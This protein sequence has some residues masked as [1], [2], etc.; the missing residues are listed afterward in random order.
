[1]SSQLET[2]LAYCREKVASEGSSL[3]YATG[4]LSLEDR[5]FWLGLFSLNQELRNACMKQFE[6]GLTQIKLGWWRNTLA[7]NED[8]ANRHPV[9]VAISQHVISSIPPEHWEALIEAVV[10]SCE[11]KRFNHQV[12]W[13]NTLKAEIRPWL[14]L[15]TARTGIDDTHAL[16]AFWVASTQVCQV[17]RLAKY[18]DS[19]F[20]PIPISLLQQHGVTAE[21]FRLRQH[22]EKTTALFQAVMHAQI[23]A[24]HA[25]WHA[26][27]VALRL[28]CRPLRALFRMRLAEFRLH[29]PH[30]LLL[31]EQKCLTPLRKFCTAWTTHVLRR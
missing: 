12:D 16:L 25:A 13:D 8:N 4:F 19:Q 9:T 2:P 20:Q 27:P 11:A 23:D 26:M 22:D 1:M 21:Q 15:M 24:A 30:L 31:T 3:H 10:S 28:F 6:A 5:A 17:L 29:S 18:L 14:P 7:N